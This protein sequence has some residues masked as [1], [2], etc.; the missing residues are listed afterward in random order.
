MP[1]FA[2]LFTNFF[3][4]TKPFFYTNVIRP[5]SLPGQLPLASEV[6]QFL[7]GFALG[8]EA[9]IG[10]IT[11]CTA[12]AKT[13]LSD[14]QAA[15]QDIKTGFSKLSLSALQRGVQELSQG[16][17]DVATTFE[18]CGIPQLVADIKRIAAEIKKGGVFE[19][20]VKEVVNVC[21]DVYTLFFFK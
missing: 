15:Y 13:T 11:Q 5:Q 3:N 9:G 20:I 2:G 8:V 14:F 21:S 1:L 16:L 12:Q 4:S 19:F 6:L 18:A 10:N 17:Q 7:E